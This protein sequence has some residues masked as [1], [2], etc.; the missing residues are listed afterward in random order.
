VKLNMFSFNNAL[1]K[2]RKLD[3]LFEKLGYS[4]VALVFVA[5][6]MLG[7][8]ALRF[9]YTQV[10]GYILP[11]EAWYYNNFVLDKVHYAYYREVFLTIYLLFFQDVRDINT[12][13]LRG[14]IFSAIWALGCVMV[15]YGIF[16]RLKVSEKATALLLLSLPL[17]PIF[18]I[19]AP[20]ILTETLG[21]FF[22]LLGL[23]F[24]VS[25]LQSYRATYALLSS[26][27]F[28]MAYKVRE[29]YLIFLAGNFIMMLLAE[30]K[31]IRSILAYAVP[32]A[33]VFPIP[34]SIQPLRFAQPVYA[35]IITMWTQLFHSPSTIVAPISPGILLQPSISVPF[36]AERVDV[37]TAFFLGLFYGYNPLFMIFTFVAL[38]L[39][40][41]SLATRK[42]VV[43]ASTALNML[44]AMLSFIVS[45]FIVVGTLANALS[46]W[47]STIVRMAHTSIPV[48]IGY[49]Y[50]YE[51]VKTKHMIVI[52]LIFLALAST[53]VPQFSYTLQRSLSA[54][55]VNRLSFDYR[56]PYFRL[57]QLAG[58]S[59]RTLVLGLHL[60]G[61]RVYMSM[62]P[63]VMVLPV[64][65]T[66]VDFQN[67]I[68][69]G[70]DT[71]F[72]YDDWLTIKVPSMLNAY[73]PY[74]RQILVSCSY[75]GYVVET[76]WVDGES[77]AIRMVKSGAV[78]I[79]ES[80]AFETFSVA[81]N[82]EP[83]HSLKNGHLGFSNEKWLDQHKS[84]N[85]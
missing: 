78:P 54:E 2:W 49:S 31:P 11:D 25:Y 7:I 51:R 69:K 55:P 12:F 42:S 48:F 50:L 82:P 53:Q 6:L 26:V 56:A 24:M 67:L 15:C 70:W 20:T 1:A 85:F 39:L 45:L 79:E 58:E 57:Y 43:A 35:L 41:R 65:S 76:L 18:T 63:N 13:I 22:A 27:A 21:L 83:V 10:T 16:K 71:I 19:L 33:L 66:E 62:L 28:L 32:M 44:L 47:T 46:G 38:G 30:K 5:A 68:G 29:P 4:R 9:Y 73:P 52:L 84:S 64:P 72:L 75:S 8:V 59:G 34:V 74:Y 80:H 36:E 81:R 77:Y 3:H 37:L 61:I 60:R 40:L 17:F 14:A 23:Y